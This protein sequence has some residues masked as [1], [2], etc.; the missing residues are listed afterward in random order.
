MGSDTL[1][2]RRVRAPLK[3]PVRRRSRRFTMLRTSNRHASHAC[4]KS[5]GCIPTPVAST[6]Q[7]SFS[8][9]AGVPPDRAVQ[10]IAQCLLARVVE[11][12]NSM[13]FITQAKPSRASG[14]A[15]PNEP[16]APGVPKAR[17]LD[18]NRAAVP[19]G[20]S[21]ATSSWAHH[22]LVLGRSGSL[23]AVRLARVAGVI[24]SSAPPSANAERLAR[25]PAPFQPRCPPGPT[26]SQRRSFGSASAKSIDFAAAT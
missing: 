20:E 7:R 17:R 14:S 26:S 13:L 3:G 16:P 10:G 19:V 24:P 22:H 5:F 25:S 21:P 8:A 18:T 9:S 6:F 4:A 23:T 11:L 1:E 15:K 12:W 2:A